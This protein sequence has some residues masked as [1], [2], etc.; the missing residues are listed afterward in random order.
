MKCEEDHQ[1]HHDSNCRL[2]LQMRLAMKW[3]QFAWKQY[4]N[5]FE[6]RKDTEC[7][8]CKDIPSQLHFVSLFPLCLFCA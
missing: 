8:L 1:H 5:D 4:R 3:E 6:C 7:L 2:L